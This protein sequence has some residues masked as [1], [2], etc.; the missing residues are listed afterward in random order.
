MSDDQVTADARL[1]LSYIDGEG[2]QIEEVQRGGGPHMG[3]LIAET[4]LQ[5]QQKYTP[6]VVPRVRRLRE[7]WPEATT[8]SAFLEH[9]ERGD[10]EDAV[11]WPAGER[12]DQMHQTAELLRDEEIETPSQLREALAPGSRR[13]DLRTRLRRIRN[14]GP[15]TLDYFDILTG[16]T[17]SAAIDV[18]LRRATTNAGIKRADYN[19]L[20]AV[21]R[22]AAELSGWRVGDL[23]ALLWAEHG[24][25]RQSTD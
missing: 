13:D 5:R 21:I 9:I 2:L 16:W 4:A 10:L 6:T 23:D 17:D 18:R 15:K 3:A 25:N 19:H 11:D 1:L 8:S 12:H 22:K 20:S 7:T 24:A 14:V